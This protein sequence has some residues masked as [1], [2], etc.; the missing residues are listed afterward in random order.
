MHTVTCGTGQVVV[1]A[2]PVTAGHS[3]AIALIPELYSVGRY[4]GAAAE[5]HL[6]PPQHGTA[7]HQN[8]VCGTCYRSAGRQVLEFRQ[9]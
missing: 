1:T 8:L 4:S 3:I 9:L 7:R 2:A 6:P 5:R